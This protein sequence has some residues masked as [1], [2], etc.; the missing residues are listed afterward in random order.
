VALIILLKNTQLVLTA[1]AGR[2]VM[3]GSLES[4]QPKIEPSGA[5]M[6]PVGCCLGLLTSS[7]TLTT[8]GSLG[9]TSCSSCCCRWWRD[10]ASTPQ[11]AAP[12]RLALYNSSHTGYCCFTVCKGGWAIWPDKRCLPVGCWWK[13]SKKPSWTGHRLVHLQTI[14]LPCG[15]CQGVPA[16]WRNLAWAVWGHATLHSWQQ[17]AV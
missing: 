14:D 13:G 17:A 9:S 3:Q 5:T 7:M 11:Q 12:W 2:W 4:Q 10:A 15:S 6:R 1:T 16:C 8:A